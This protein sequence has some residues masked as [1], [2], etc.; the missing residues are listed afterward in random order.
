MFSE[1]PTIPYLS[2]LKN[3]KSPTLRS[4]HDLSQRC[5]SEKGPA[6]V[7]TWRPFHS[8][9][10]I[11]LAIPVTEQTF[12]CYFDPS[13][14]SFLIVPQEQGIWRASI[15]HQQFFGIYWWRL[16]FGL[17]WAQGRKGPSQSEGHILQPASAC[18]EQKG[19]GLP[20][21]QIR[22]TGTE[23]PSPLFT[24]L[25][26]AFPFTD[27][28]VWTNHVVILSMAVR[29]FIPSCLPSGCSRTLSNTIMA[30][31]ADSKA[32]SGPILRRTFLFSGKYAWHAENNWSHM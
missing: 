11:V 5:T 2:D 19:G 15:A 29:Y 30:A 3:W 21:E 28:P 10:G 31:Y 17:I 32:A 9:T 26:G 14:Y 12:Q 18:R 13:E 23:C 6:R 24:G 4:S 1:E 27:G 22:S 25:E 8:R 7:Q 20:M 16:K